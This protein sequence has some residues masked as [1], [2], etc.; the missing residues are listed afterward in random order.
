VIGARCNVND[1]PR[2]WI[3]DSLVGALY[4]GAGANGKLA[5]HNASGLKKLNTP[6]SQLP[7]SE[8]RFTQVED[9]G[10]KDVLGSQCCVRILFKQHEHGFGVRSTSNNDLST[11]HNILA[12]NTGKSPAANASR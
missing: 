6:S 3:R 8:C 7:E 4:S 5:L 11:K 12:A 9:Q 2:S 1:T 10:V